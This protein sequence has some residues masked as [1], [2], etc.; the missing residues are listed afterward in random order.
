[1]ELREEQAGAEIVLD[2][3]LGTVE[4]IESYL[5]RRI[6]VL[7]AGPFAQALQANKVNLEFAD[8]HSN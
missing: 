2:T 5:E 6:R 1:M 7:Y 3:V 4:E 8:Y